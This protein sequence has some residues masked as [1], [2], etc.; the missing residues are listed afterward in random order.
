MTNPENA[1]WRE[2]CEQAL[3]EHDP[4]LLKPL[5]HKCEA[6]IIGRLHEIRNNVGH[7][8]E[9]PA[10]YAAQRMLRALQIERLHYP[11]TPPK[12]SP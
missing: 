5:I 10:I 2:L 12:S 9:L 7:E 3:L 6:A 4:E 1:V 8:E 11:P